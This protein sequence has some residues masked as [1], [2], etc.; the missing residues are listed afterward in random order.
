MDVEGGQKVGISSAMYN[1]RDVVDRVR[2]A[3]IR[4]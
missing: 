1:I 3:L 2:S 4:S